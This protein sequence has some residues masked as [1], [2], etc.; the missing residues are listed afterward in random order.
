MEGAVS[1]TSRL[2]LPPF[3]IWSGLNLCCDF[4]AP[5]HKARVAFALLILAANV[6]ANAV[7]HTSMCI[8]VTP[9]TDVSAAYQER[10][11]GGSTFSSAVAW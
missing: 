6:T 8:R 10:Q 2:S 7:I 4:V 11:D 1:P 5:R 3:A 9:K